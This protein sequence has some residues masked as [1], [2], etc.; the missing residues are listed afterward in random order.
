V[1]FAAIAIMLGVVFTAMSFSAVI[2]LAFPLSPIVI[3]IAAFLA[4][5]VTPVM[6]VSRRYG[7]GGESQ[8]CPAQANPDKTQTHKSAN[9]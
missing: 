9:S 4:L 8:Y 2:A 6:A 3:H 5:F 7:E 1:I